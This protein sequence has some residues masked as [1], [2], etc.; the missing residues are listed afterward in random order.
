MVDECWLPWHYKSKTNFVFVPSVTSGSKCRFSSFTYV[1]INVTFDLCVVDTRVMVFFTIF[2]FFFLQGDSEEFSSFITLVKG[3]DRQ[4][5]FQTGKLRPPL[6]P[7]LLLS[8]FKHQQLIRVTLLL[9]GQR[10]N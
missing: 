5:L 4:P 8:L 3:S 2:L 7:E 9:P 6:G 10:S 1:S